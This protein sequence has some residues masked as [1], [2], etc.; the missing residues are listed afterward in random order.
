MARF[1]ASSISAKAYPVKVRKSLEMLRCQSLRF[2]G[3]AQPGKE[4]YDASP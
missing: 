2:D 3:E 1:G 4:A